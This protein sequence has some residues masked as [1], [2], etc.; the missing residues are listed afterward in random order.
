MTINS[1]CMNVWVC[2]GKCVEYVCVHARMYAAAMCSCSHLCECDVRRT[3][4]SAKSCRVFDSV[5]CEYQW[6]HRMC[7]LNPT[8]DRWM[9]K[10]VT[11]TTCLNRNYKPKFPR[12]VGWASLNLHPGMS[13]SSMELLHKQVLG[14]WPIIIWALLTL[15]DVWTAVWL[16]MKSWH[17]Q[18]VVIMHGYY[19]V[20]ASSVYVVTLYRRNVITPQKCKQ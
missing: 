18:Q 17:H 8:L 15:Q 5:H 11:C 7:G 9:T 20:S 19:Q 16:P 14:N 1:D 6:H 10:E 3:I 12:N 4:I 13:A 2:M